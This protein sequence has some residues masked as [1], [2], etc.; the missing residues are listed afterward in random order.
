MSI[1]RFALGVAML[2]AS[3]ALA[4]NAAPADTIVVS[5]PR[6]T[7]LQS[8]V[9]VEDDQQSSPDG[10]GF[11]A[12]QPGAA[13]IDNGALSGQVQLRGLFG[14]RILLRINGQ[15]FATGG[16]N[17]MDPP[18]HYAP[19]VLIDRVEIAR[20]VSPVRDGPG[21]GGGVNAVL[22]QVQFG[23]GDSLSPQVD[24]TGQYRSVDNSVAAGGIAGLASKDLRLGLIASWEHG[25]D[26]RFPGGRI[27]GTSFRRGVYGVHAGVRTGPGTLS[28]EYRRQETGQSGNPPF[29]MDIIYFHT[30]FA[31]LGFEGDVGDGVQIATHA[32]YTA[33][34][35]RMNNFTLRAAPELAMQRQTDTYAN[36]LGADVALRFG[37]EKR[38][39]R[40]GADLQQVD[41][42]YVINN[43]AMPAFFVHALDNGQSERIAAFA[44]WRTGAGPVEAELGVR[45]DRHRASVAAPRFGPGV[46]VG[47]ANLARAFGNGPRD[48]QGTTVDAA[49]RLWAEAGAFTPRLTL[50]RKTR[51]PS[52]IERFSWLPTE[53]SGGLADGNI[54]VGD[55]RLKPET[56]WIAELGFDWQSASDY[57]R[58]V[59]YYRRV[60]DFM[61]GVPFDATPAVVDTPVEM[62]SAANGDASPLRFANVDAEIWGADIAFGTRI[63]GPLR[64]DG[65]A[66]YV[67]GRRRDVP[68]N[69]YRIA[70]ANGRLALAWDAT[71]WMIAVEV[72]GFAA[73]NRIAT[74][75][76]E[77]NSRGYVLA[78]L[79]GNWQV[80]DGLRLDFGMENLFNRQYLEH[81]AGYNRIRLSD[82]PVGARLSGPG[83]SAFIRLRWALRS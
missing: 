51:V 73:Q 5:A 80:A 60:D 21:L 29:A 58:P 26:T 10:A 55:A 17:A 15:N 20:G 61:Q 75:N 69:L 68:D 52:L 72:Q 70:P 57:A 81:L 46:P 27:A 16:P 64:L 65:I 79:L 18:L 1:S 8:L 35:H 30:D 82:V 47:P 14:A 12:R 53:A 28:L 54:Y 34:R 43:P 37:S 24:V 76:S 44:E 66:S 63:A 11:I 2:A 59:I 9:D 7:R 45:V 71:D 49:L 13:L 41:N 38:H 67:R 50:A 36:T 62:V 74:T 40:I 83:R 22:K 56:A 77:V 19:M 4:D 25:D 23:T 48:W 32:D 42:G 31:R 39:L 6:I 78:S 33:V 3:P